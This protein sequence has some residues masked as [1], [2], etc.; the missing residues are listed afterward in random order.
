MIVQNRDF[1]NEPMFKSFLYTLE[2]TMDS[3]VITSTSPQEYFLYV[4]EAFKRKTGY[5]ESDLLGKSPR[6]LQG[7]QTSRIVLDELKEK[8]Q[9]GENFIG[10]NTNYRKDGSKYI[11]KWY[12]S[13]L[14]DIKEQTIAYIS[15]QKEMTQSIWEHKQV[16]YLA[17]VTNQIDQ[18]VIVTDLVGKIVYMNDSYVR[19]TGYKREYL[20]KKNIKFIRSGKHTKS[21]YKNI[22]LLLLNN[23][24]FHGTM[25]N[26]RQNGEL[27]FE[28]K[29]ISP[30]KNDEGNI[31][32]FV[33]I[34]Q[35]ITEIIEQSEEYRNKAYH[36]T[37][38]GLGNRLKFD[39][40]I[41]RKYIEFLKN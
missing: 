20:L 30:I 26:K 5:T 14:K 11:V 35:D 40:I 18:M 12:V 13:A 10:Q 8:L 4:N 23:E 37:L 2:N 19:G 27:F 15:Y 7:P 9:K 24:S 21:F 22:W 33:S 34:G 41:D 1:F 3:V 16:Q 38:T 29:T 31:E 6:I 39:E 28:K 17:A 32:F 25:I 36:D